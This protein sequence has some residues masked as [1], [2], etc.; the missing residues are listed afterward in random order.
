VIRVA[1][2]GLGLMGLRHAQ[3][4]RRLPG[5]ELSAIV[6]RRPPER[7]LAD[8]AELVHSMALDPDLAAVDGIPVA[9]S[10]EEALEGGGIDAAVI[11]L[12]AADHAWAARRC[13]D[14]GLH[15]FVEKPLCLDL[16]EGRK[17]IELAVRRRR[18]LLVGHHTRF[19]PAYTYLRECFQ[20]GRL[21]GMRLLALF[22]AGGRPTWGSWPGEEAARSAGGSLFDLQI[23]DVDFCRWVLGEP[24]AVRTALSTESYLD[25]VLSYP[26]SLE[27]CIQG[28][29]LTPRLPYESFFVAEFERGGLQ[30]RRGGTPSLW[31]ADA[32]TVRPV[33]LGGQ[34]EAYRAELEHFL[35]LISGRERPGRC[36]PSSCLESVAL[37]HRI[38]DSARR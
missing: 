16:G 18:V 17:L 5:L 30:Y 25:T 10:I 21:G 4:V 6:S 7:L 9:G 20:S 27:V 14:R 29:W 38:R 32:Q 15:V 28:G 35:A 33:E 8:A 13:L 11:C 23:H 3:H 26:A 34:T 31:E 12:P 22:R 24:A 37:C 2:V 36:T 19:D 1:V